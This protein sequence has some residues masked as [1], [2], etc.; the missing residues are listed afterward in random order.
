MVK[1]GVVTVGPC[2]SAENRS[3]LGIKSLIVHRLGQLRQWSGLGLD[4][5]FKR[6]NGEKD[7]G[8]D[9]DEQR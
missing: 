4:R 8:Q 1:R 9:D 3:D 5:S 2:A 6:V 7:D